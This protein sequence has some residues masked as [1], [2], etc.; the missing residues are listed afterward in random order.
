MIRKTYHLELISPCLCSGADPAKAEIRPA[1][2]RG[3]LRWWFR[4]LGGTP[5]SE[6]AIF[7]SAAGDEGKGSAIRITVSDVIPGSAWSPPSFSPNDATSYVW[8]FAR[9][10][11]KSDK[12]PHGPRWQTKGALKEGTNFL[13]N[14]TFIRP[15]SG[16]LQQQFDDSL[17]AFL[18]FG[19]IGLRNT[20]GLGA[21]RC[22]ELQFAQE[23]IDVLQKKGFI[24]SQ[25]L[26][27]ESF[28]T[29]QDAIRDWSSWL[30]Y[31]LRK[32][33]KAES[34]SALGGIS[35]RQTS[36]I[37]FRPIKLESGKYT[38]LAFEAPHDRVLAGKL[39][40]LLTRNI[41]SGAAPTAPN[42]RR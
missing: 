31:D 7:G 8:H 34:P 11:G 14:L 20:R 39:P 25:R 4:A 36:A 27:P 22:R 35:P 2:I 30:R 10:S 29:L 28:D 32:K 38:W 18:L 33:H 41:F 37:R 16:S 12:D 42:R 40:T 15:L 9:E 6:T 17:Q 21:F 5:E 13:L 26:N 19:A 23:Q 3:Q 1:S 24:V